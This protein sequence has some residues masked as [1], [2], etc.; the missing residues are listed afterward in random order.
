[1]PL[2]D[3]IPIL[4]DISAAI[5]K[6][7]PDATEANR[8]AGELDKTQ[9]ALAQAQASITEAEGQSPSLFKSGWRPATGW[10]CVLGLWLDF[11]FF[12]LVSMGMQLAGKA[13]LVSPL[14]A[15]S[16]LALLG[17][18]LGLGSMRTYEKYKG[19]A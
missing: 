13:P 10:M 4:G 11:I 5:R 16:L 18:L 6:A 7:V 12:P 8:I 14:D 17:S 1:M 19:K 15:A 9:L 2:L 3:F